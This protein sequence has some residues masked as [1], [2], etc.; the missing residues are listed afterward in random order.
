MTPPCLNPDPRVNSLSP[1]LDVFDL[2]VRLETD[3]VTNSVARAQYGYSSTWDMAVAHFPLQMTPD[4]TAPGPSAPSRGWT[5]YLRGSSFALPLLL[6]CAAMLIFQYSLWGGAFTPEY[7][8]AVAIG[9]TSSFIVSGGFVQAMARRGHFYFGCGQFRMCSGSN[10]QWLW[11]GA[12]T[13]T[14][15]CLVGILANAYFNWMPALYAGVAAV[16]LLCLG[17]F[18]LAVGVLYMLGENLLVSASLL[19]GLVAVIL[20][21]SIFRLALIPAQVVGILLA[22]AFAVAAFTFR[23]RPKI[24]RDTGRAKPLLPVVE[25]Y[26]AWPYF[27]YGL[28]YHLFLFC[29]RMLAWTAGTES[30]SLSIQFRGGYEMAMNVGL[31]AF[32]L[33][34]GWVHYALTIYQRRLKLSLS[35]FQTDQIG[36]FTQDLNSFHRRTTLWFIPVAAIS[37]LAVY[38]LAIYSGFVVGSLIKTTA[39]WALLGVPFLVV[40]LWNTSLLFALS[41]PLEVI[42]ALGSGC[43]ANLALGYLASR[44]GSY[45][46]AVLGFTAGAVLFALI[47]SHFCVRTFRRLDYYQYAAAL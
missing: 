36:D 43:A 14:T 42:V 41:R 20:A 37:T 31:A 29:D 44:I 1:P 8:T 3:G 4:E 21:H 6:S 12:C 33:Q 45:Q 40:G 16:F 18:W 15:L 17:L 47:S 34:V 26:L 25:L 2:T 46:H 30:S 32:I 39:I 35:S 27:V 19:V 22:T 11:W 38:S 13:I 10:R 7:A 23:M 5:E 28:L 24:R 9:A